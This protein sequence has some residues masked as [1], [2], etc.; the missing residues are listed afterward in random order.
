MFPDIS[1]FLEDIS[2]YLILATYHNVMKS[3]HVHIDPFYV[4]IAAR[5]S[6]IPYDLPV[7][8]HPLL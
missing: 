1:L 6:S 5:E 8:I 2:F 3:D 4:D 7:H